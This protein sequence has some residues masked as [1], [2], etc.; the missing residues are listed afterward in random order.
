MPTK[1]QPAGR[2]IKDKEVATASH[3]ELLIWLVD[4]LAGVC[5]SFLAMSPSQWKVAVSKAK[6]EEIEW[7]ESKAVPYLARYARGEL[8]SN[9]YLM[10]ETSELSDE[11]KA[12]LKDAICQLPAAQRVI[13]AFEV[14]V[15]SRN[16][17][18]LKHEA[19]VPVVLTG[20]RPTEAYVDLF[21]RVQYPVAVE[22]GLEHFPSRLAY[23]SRLAS[24]QHDSDPFRW[25]FYDQGFLKVAQALIDPHAKVRTNDRELDLWFTV[26]SDPFTL[27]EVL[28][29]LKTIRSLGSRERLVGL[30]THSVSSAIRRHVEHEGFFVVERQSIGAD[31]LDSVEPA[32]GDEGWTLPS[33]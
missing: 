6:V 33:M 15:D 8:Q 16:V 22:I 7:L 19:M 12:A 10:N 25:E 20:P 23:L 13:E 17:K 4:N 21:A 18:L 31:S 9:G 32:S 1:Q 11:C 29:E 28:Q 30:V 2:K 27:G 24:S 3:D 14:D 5:N 26:R